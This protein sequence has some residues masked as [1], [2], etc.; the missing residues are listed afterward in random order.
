MQFRRH[1][2][3]ISF[4]GILLKIKVG[5]RACEFKRVEFGYFDDGSSGFTFGITLRGQLV[6]NLRGLRVLLE[7]HP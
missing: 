2:Y 3:Q 1:S 4:I 6:R 7:S 5:D